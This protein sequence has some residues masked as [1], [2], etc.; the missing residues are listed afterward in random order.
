MAASLGLQIEEIETDGFFVENLGPTKILDHYHKFYFYINLTQIEINFS[1]LWTN[2]YILSLKCNDS[3]PLINYLK[4]NCF[5]IEDELSKLVFRNKRSIDSLGSAIRFVTGNLDQDDLK[6]LN[7]QLKNLFNND[8]KIVNQIHKFTSFANH[9]TNRYI[10]D[11]NIM[12]DN[13]NKSMQAINEIDNEFNLGQ[14]ILYNIYLSQKLISIIKSVQRTITLAFNDVTNL[15]IISTSELEAIIDH[16]KQIYKKEQLLDLDV[17]HLFKIIE[18][19]KF[20]IVSID[21]TLT[22]ILYI[23]IL[24]T[25]SLTYQRIYPIPNRFGQIILPPAKFRLHNSKKELWTEEQCPHI[26]THILCTKRQTESKCSINKLSNC[27]FA[28]A[29]NEY[30]VS[31]QLKNNKILFSCKTPTK[32]LENC[33]NQIAYKEV[34]GSYLI[35][36]D[37]QCR[38]IIDDVI[39][40]NAFSNFTYQIPKITSET[41]KTKKLIHLKSKHL[42]DVGYLKSEAEE[43]ENPIELHTFIQKGHFLLTTILFIVALTGSIILVSKKRCISSLWRKQTMVVDDEENIAELSTLTTI[44]PKLP[45]A[46][47]DEDVL[48]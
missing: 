24:Q 31:I 20:S 48:S 27:N 21:K 12:Q 45:T 47:Q 4:E 23:P 8:Q 25:E 28:E 13:L 16:L 39:F 26:E 9:I 37:N 22:C 34:N 17:L 41:F 33:G 29:I 43:L 1:N 14:S 35:S 3:C 15:E 6:T 38:V 36:S 44:Y 10:N 11:L 46:P 2:S 19:S 42:D 18:F 7:T 5:E 32:I 40:E 30:R